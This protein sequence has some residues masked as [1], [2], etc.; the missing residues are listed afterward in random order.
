MWAQDNGAP[1]MMAPA[2]FAMLLLAVAVFQLLC[3][4]P[5]LN[6]SDSLPG[7]YSPGAV[8]GASDSMYVRT[9][10]PKLSIHSL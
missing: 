5:E 10:L 9:S 4:S 8:H 2:V 1:A 7:R 3:K 6:M